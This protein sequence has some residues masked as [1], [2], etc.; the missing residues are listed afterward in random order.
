[1][2]DVE[3]P[4]LLGELVVRARLL[5][6]SS[7]S[8]SRGRKTASNSSP[9]ARWQVSRCTPRARRRPD[10]SAAAVGDERGARH[11]VELL[12]ERDEPREVG[13]THEL[14]LAELVRQHSSQPASSAARARASAPRR[15]VALERRSSRRAA[16]RASSDEPWNGMPASCSTS[17]KS[18]R[19]AFVRRRT[20]TSSSGA[21]RELPG[22]RAASHASS[23]SASRTAAAPAPGRP[24]RCA[25]HLLGAAE[26]RHKPVRELEHLRRRAVV[27]L[28]PDDRRLG[29]RRGTPSSR[30]GAAPVNA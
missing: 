24:A 13:L 18:A 17:S 26:P 9:F 21:R 2:P 11:V 6:G 15:A 29:N 22:S 1:M 12:G 7:F 3:Q 4:P 23:A 8:S 28:E 19:R 16:S 20:A 5:D 30:S 10:R 14:A 25:Q 27:L